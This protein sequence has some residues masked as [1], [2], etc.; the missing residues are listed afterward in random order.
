MTTDYKNISQFN[1]EQLGKDRAS[2]MSQVAMYADTAHFVYELLQNADDAGATEIHF[3]VNDEQLVVEHNGTLFT[4]DNVKA[5]SYFGKGKTDI[6]KIGH[7]GLGFKSVFAY[8]ASPSVHSG[9]ESFEITQ[10]YSVAA[11]PYPTDL[12]RG[13]TRFV[14]PFDHLIS[15]PDYI[16]YRKL[17]PTKK[18]CE[19]IVSK[20]ANLG[21]RTLLFTK[22]LKEIKWET[23]GSGG[24]YLRE[25]TPFDANGREIYIITGN[26]EEQ[27]FLVFDR[28][29][30]WKDEDGEDKEHRPVQI[31]FALNKRLVDG[32]VIEA[33]EDA[34]L[35]VFFSTAMETHVGLIL[36]GPYRTTPARDNIPSDDEFNRHLVQETAALLAESLLHIKKLERLNLDVLAI[37]P[38]NHDRFREGTF[39]YPLYSTVRDAL[40]NHPLL[41]TSS[42]GYV[43]GTQAKLARGAELTK[44]FGPSQLEKLF[45]NTGLKWLAP[46]LTQNNYPNLHQLLVGKKAQAARFQ[47]AEWIAPPLAPN[48]EVGAE[49]IAKLI[50]AE[51]MSQQTDQWVIRFYEYLSELGSGSGN[52]SFFTRQPI[53]RLDGDK[54]VVPFSDND[55]PNAFLPSEDEEDEAVTGLPTVKRTLVQK[56]ET[57]QF[58]EDG[59]RLTTPDIADLVLKRVIPKYTDCKGIDIKTWQRDF[60]QILKAMGTDSY[61][62][63]SR[64]ETALKEALFL[65]AE[66]IGVEEK[67]L[68]VKAQDAYL[69]TEENRLFFAGCEEIYLLA[70]EQ[71]SESD[72]K[73]LTELGVAKTPRVTKCDP[74]HQGYMSLHH[75]HGWHKRGLDGFDPNWQ[76]EGLEN[77]VNVPT[78]DRSELLWKYLLPNAQCI[79]G[80]V[81]KSNRQTFENA[82]R[83]EVIS[84]KGKLLM[85]AA[86][87]PD[88]QNVFHTPDELGLDDLPDVFL[89]SA[90]N[91]KE[92][93][94]KL[95]M[96][97]PEQQQALQKLGQGDPRR[98]KLLEKIS[99]AS[100]SELDAFEK[101]IPKKVAPQPAP[102]F[103]DAL[104][105]LMRS[106]RG[107]VGQI[108]A[109]ATPVTNPIR[110]GGKLGDGVQAAIKT[111]LT[112]PHIVT[113]S[114][115]RD[116]QSN[117]QARKLLYSEYQ[118]KCQVTGDTF[119]KA[120]TNAEGVAE[121]YFEACALLSYSNADYLNDAGNM[122]CVSA[123][124]MAKLKNAS[125]EWV[126]D[127]ETAIEEF[128]QAGS[129]PERIA[130]RVQL[131]G[132]ECTVTWSQRHFM[133]LI[134][135]WEKA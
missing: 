72:L 89:K 79:R 42:H 102:P 35:Y 91:A 36:Q 113:F 73:T 39:F 104:K 68:F 105:E 32:G 119:P 19:E 95:G 129:A 24:H 80:V 97:Q 21:A 41:P 8:T 64:L 83:E 107:D 38:I 76:M 20:L 14:L 77:V 29:I 78:L 58:L 128:Q 6:T 49:Q 132:E 111:H 71:Y 59:I 50:T 51:F 45:G 103:K 61:E 90:G 7:F 66:E 130:V 3:R 30:F 13:R 118:G 70:H 16:E 54:H 34:R 116:Q 4:E 28:A 40:A 98:M 33:V 69:N 127:I 106:Q 26:P 112:S 99:S 60:R 55:T 5:I 88:K 74:N 108:N 126:D 57:R 1:E 37:L 125:F 44:V 53:I 120:S 52:W 2:R 67:F 134:A 93:A 87:L 75:S 48:I 101:L 62:K 17:K 18:A 92:L 84:D 133:H 85:G 123:D 10:L 12:K 117:S 15:K 11:T 86:W 121:N 109:N 22:S 100:D 82:K 94:E 65:L 81:E 114:P 63:K 135:L 115:V 27:C 43:S 23:E 9:D 25:D 56:E 122:L 31:A 46:E 131:A 124:T 110:Y 96:K 47:Q